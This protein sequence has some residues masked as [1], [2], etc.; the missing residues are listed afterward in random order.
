M[1]YV[2]DVDDEGGVAKIK[3]FGD[4]ISNVDKKAGRM[5]NTM[6]NQVT[7]ANNK[8]EKSYSNLGVAMQAAFGAV[9]VRQMVSFAK[10]AVSAADK[11]IKADMK[12]ENVLRSTG[13][14]VGYTLGELKKMASD[15]QGKSLFGDETI[16]EAQAIML[17]F[18]RIGRDVFPEMLSIGTDMASFLNQDMKQTF[19]QLGKAIND[20]IKGLSALSRVGVSF[21]LEQKEQI[22]NFIKQ[23]D[24]IS[25]QRVMLN[26]LKTEFGGAA[27]AAAN[28]GAGGLTQFQNKLGDTVELIGIRILPALDSVTEKLGYFNDEFSTY[29][30]STEIGIDIQKEYSQKNVELQKQLDELER[31]KRVQAKFDQ[32]RGKARIAEINSEMEAIKKTMASNEQVLLRDAKLQQK[33]AKDRE[34]AAKEKPKQDYTSLLG[35]NY[36][37]KQRAAILKNQQIKDD[38]YSSLLSDEARA[39]SEIDKRS[40]EYLKAGANSVLV[41]RKAENDKQKIREEFSQKRLKDLHDRASKQ[42]EIAV[43]E[44]EI[45]EDAQKKQAE[46][47]RL[48]LSNENQAIAA[49]EDRKDAYLDAGVSAVDAERW[50]ESEKQKI[51]DQFREEEVLKEKKAQDEKIK[52]YTDAASNISNM[53]SNLS[54]LARQYTA[55][56]ISEIQ[57]KFDSQIEKVDEA[58]H[59][60]IMSAGNSATARNA[61]EKK[62]LKNKEKLEK[63]KQK[64]EEDAR[65]ETFNMT[66]HLD[67][68]SALMNTGVAI[69]NALAT[70]GPF[71]LPLAAAYGAMGAAQVAL[72]ESQ[73]LVVGGTPTG[74]NAVVMMNEDGRQE[75]IVNS[76]G[77]STVGRDFVNAA[78]HGATTAELAQLL[79]DGRQGGVSISISVGG[80]VTDQRV[81][82]DHLIPAIQ[83][84]LRRVA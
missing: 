1:K 79:G 45:I 49:I 12:L 11:Q 69:T 10:T 70:G 48:L 82:D 63:Q 29:L 3:R 15:L 25:A 32:G 84:S 64:A 19:I 7:P 46:F 80:L 37:N 28:A 56:E 67:S 41:E 8:A 62:Y 60:E 73:K 2:I 38:F 30:K 36:L 24:I 43:R 27:Q 40:N 44:N 71:A 6:N 31:K 22:K 68:L 39:L 17:T 61:I 52:L 13:N 81:I 74:R 77:Y 26:E 14:Q 4:E 18:T 76:R 50:A 83:R 33:L 5:S 55:Q 58:Y 59:R 51:R 42:A 23:N 78:N 35:E 72:I 16:Q 53:A 21:S 9:A 20:P 57:K 34:K 75:A 66:K 54:L 47:Y 65:R